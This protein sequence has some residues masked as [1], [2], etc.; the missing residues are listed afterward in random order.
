M[1]R[2]P[3]AISESNIYH[4]VI[5][6]ADRQQMFE[7][8]ND[9]AKYLDIL[10]YYKKECQFEIYAY[11]LM[12]NHVHLLIHTP[13]TPLATVFRR[14]NTRYAVW[15][16]MKYDRTGFL[17]QGR[18][19][20]EPVNDERYLLTVVRYIHQHPYK[21][22][23]E[24]FP[25][26]AYPWSSIYSYL[27]GNSALVD[28]GLINNLIGDSN[29]FTTFHRETEGADCLDIHKLTKRLPDDVA[30]E[31]IIKE[32]GCPTITDFQLLPLLEQKKYLVHLHEQG[33]SIRQLNRLTGTSK[34]IIQRTLTE[35]T[36][37]NSEPQP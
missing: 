7:E 2:K 26:E 35:G 21:A 28:I 10:G 32:T 36:P 12:S 14:I 25:G 23:I 13:N 15:F 16:N 37:H 9:Y 34:G 4:V 1:P 3:R 19:H 30:K 22:G 8:N 5:R 27:S 24:A 6:G 17:Q 18:Y 31:L 11:C 33:I 29:A 20:S